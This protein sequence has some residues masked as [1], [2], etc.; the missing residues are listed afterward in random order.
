MLLS[1]LP[2]SYSASRLALE[3]KKVCNNEASESSFFMRDRERGD[4]HGYAADE[5]G[6]SDGSMPEISA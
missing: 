2:L 5:G 3:T 6:R 1:R 4:L